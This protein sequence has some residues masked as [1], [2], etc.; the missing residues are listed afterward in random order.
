MNNAHDEFIE[1]VDMSQEADPVTSCDICGKDML[2]EETAI[3]ITTGD[4]SAIA[5]GFMADETAWLYVVCKDC[6]AKIT[7]AVEK[8]IDNLG[9]AKKEGV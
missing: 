5:C 2:D 7:D 3:G 8:M 6:G 4:I 9:N 1:K